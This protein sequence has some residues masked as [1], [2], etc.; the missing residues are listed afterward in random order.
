M[1]DERNMNM[2]YC[3]YDSD[4]GKPTYSVRD[5]SECP[6]I[7]QKCFVDWPDIEAMSQ[8]R[9]AEPWHAYPVQTVCST[10]HI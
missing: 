1:V 10:M 6:F 4:R 7:Y 5:L 3:Q 2:E 8:R 9:E